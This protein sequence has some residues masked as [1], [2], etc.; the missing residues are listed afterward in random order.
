MRSLRYGQSGRA[1][2]AGRGQVRA[3][4]PRRLRVCPRLCPRARTA[5]QE[6]VTS[7]FRPRS[8]K[9]PAL[10]R[11]T[12]NCAL[13]PRLVVDWMLPMECLGG[14]VCRSTSTSGSRRRR[15]SEAGTKS[16]PRRRSGSFYLKPR[17][18]RRESRYA[19]IGT[20]KANISLP[21]P[22]WTCRKTSFAPASGCWPSPWAS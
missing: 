19:S 21:V 4:R 11:S 12:A 20:S 8:R 7:C 16:Q 15:V 3:H 18:L 22:S 2:Q 14:L 13:D 17:L 6:P 9:R 1:H 10:E 5:R